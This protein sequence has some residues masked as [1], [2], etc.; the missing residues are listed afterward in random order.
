M[1][2]AVREA[3]GEEMRIRLGTVQPIDA[4]YAGWLAGSSPATIGYHTNCGMSFPAKEE[5]PHGRGPGWQARAVAA[6]LRECST[7]GP[8]PIPPPKK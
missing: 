6:V 3:E 7:G 2:T 1:Q 5:L 8:F 4:R